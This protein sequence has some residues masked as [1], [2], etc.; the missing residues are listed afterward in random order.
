MRAGGEGCSST[1]YVSLNKLSTMGFNVV[2]LGGKKKK[3]QRFLE[4]FELFLFLS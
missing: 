1:L 3:T 4:L 2:K